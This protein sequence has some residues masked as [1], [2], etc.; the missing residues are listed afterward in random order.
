MQIANVL[1]WE[2]KQG[3][4]IT[5]HGRTVTLAAQ[6]LCLRTPFGGFV[7]NRPVAVEVDEG[8]LVTRQPIVD[9]TR[10]A[11]WAIA[12]GTLL[13]TLITGLLRRRSSSAEE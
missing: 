4:T 10:M 6:A 1:S 8:G 12:G 11:L 3:P 9:V 2:T 5:A 13:V 7:W